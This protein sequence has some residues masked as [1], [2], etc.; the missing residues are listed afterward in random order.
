ML[1]RMYPGVDEAK[2]AEKFDNGELLGTVKDGTGAMVLKG[3]VDLVDD[4]VAALLN[5]V[6]AST[7]PTIP[8]SEKVSSVASRSWVYHPCRHRSR[9][10][11]M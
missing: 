10:V 8:A 6:A 11:R 4:A 1:C 2:A 5:K 9:R 3:A 7:K